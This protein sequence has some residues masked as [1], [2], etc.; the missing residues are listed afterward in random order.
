MRHKYCSPKGQPFIIP[1]I[2][3]FLPSSTFLSFWRAHQNDGARSIEL[4]LCLA[5]LF[6]NQDQA[7]SHIQFV[8]ACQETSSQF[9]FFDQVK[10]LVW[11]KWHPHFF[12]YQSHSYHMPISK[13]W[14]HLN[15]YTLFVNL[16]EK[17][18]LWPYLHLFLFIDS[19]NA[20]KVGRTFANNITVTKGS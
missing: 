18:G 20:R 6:I 11:H 14:F 19:L 16:G 2:F 7:R 12:F 10:L 5:Q 1:Q 9:F 13:I 4:D 15:W 8:D 17:V 3:F